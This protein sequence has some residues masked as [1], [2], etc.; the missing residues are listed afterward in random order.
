MKHS[1]SF[2]APFLVALLVCASFACLA[3]GTPVS[4]NLL[5]QLDAASQTALH[6]AAQLPPLSHSRSLDRW[7]DSSTNGLMAIQPWAG[8]RPVF[9]TDGTEAFVRFDGKD[10]YL[11]LSLLIPLW[12]R[13]MS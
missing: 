12:M 9:R 8:G 2:R 4:A 7:L 1:N 11:S 5:L 3:A 13:G 6:K 10:D